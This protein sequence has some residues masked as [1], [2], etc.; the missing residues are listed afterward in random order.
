M[1]Q[2]YIS[3]AL[4]SIS[5]ALKWFEVYLNRYLSVREVPVAFHT[6]PEMLDRLVNWRKT[7]IIEGCDIQSISKCP[8]I[9][10]E[11]HTPN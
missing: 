6:V 4:E 9:I 1:V 2:K 3:E 7:H 10:T 8:V 5:E 11:P